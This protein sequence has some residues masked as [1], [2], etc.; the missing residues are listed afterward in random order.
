MRLL[1]FSVR[2][3]EIRAGFRKDGV[4]ETG[5]LPNPFA[6]LFWQEVDILKGPS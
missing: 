6:T 1:L 3:S 5:S 4:C 2:Q